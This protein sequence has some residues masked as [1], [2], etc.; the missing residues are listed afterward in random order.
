MNENL[1]NDLIEIIWP[2]LDAGVSVDEIQCAITN[3][4]DSWEPVKEI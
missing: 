4:I 3:V 1:V 2:K